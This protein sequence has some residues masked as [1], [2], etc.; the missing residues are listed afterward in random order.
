[1]IRKEDKML[2]TIYGVLCFLCLIFAPAAF[3]GGMY[4]TSLVLIAFVWVFY[5][6]S[7]KESGRIRRRRKR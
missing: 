5:R 2:A 4:I 6:L 7:E 1:M 3:E